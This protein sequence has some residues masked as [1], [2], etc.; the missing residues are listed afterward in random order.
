[1]AKAT[2]LGKNVYTV[3]DNGLGVWQVR[4]TFNANNIEEAT[5][6]MQSYARYHG[7][8]ENGYRVR[9]A[10]TEEIATDWLRE[11]GWVS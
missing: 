2:K 10:T 8:N 6:K 11:N 5:R 4:F 9:E 7:D 3:E 1:M